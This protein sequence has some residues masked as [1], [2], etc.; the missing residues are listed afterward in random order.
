M[1][2]EVIAFSDL[3]DIEISDSK[4]LREVLDQEFSVQIISVSDRQKTII[5]RSMKGLKQIRETYDVRYCAS[6]AG[7]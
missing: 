3:S 7:I 2:A 1:E 5:R 4:E 6:T